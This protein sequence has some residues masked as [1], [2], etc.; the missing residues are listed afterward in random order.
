MKKNTL[1]LSLLACCIVVLS[2][3][4]KKNAADVVYRGT[5]I[6]S[7]CGVAMIALTDTTAAVHGGNWGN[8][9]NVIG[10]RNYCLLSDMNVSIGS[11]LSFKVSDTNVQPGSNCPVPAC[12]TLW[13]AIQPASAYIYEVKK[14]N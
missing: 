7:Q 12:I 10:V 4:C 8:A 3:A 13:T 14:L 9:K 5:L 6:S 11:F 1:L 2:S